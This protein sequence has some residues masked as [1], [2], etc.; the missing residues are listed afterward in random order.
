MIT[1]IDNSILHT[2]KEGT[3][4]KLT[5][6]M[7]D[8]YANM[9]KDAMRYQYELCKKRIELDKLKENNAYYNNKLVIRNRRNVATDVI[10]TINQMD[11]RINNMVR[12]LSI[13]LLISG[14]SIA[15]ICYTNTDKVN[16]S[17]GNFYDTIDRNILPD[18]KYIYDTWSLDDSGFISGYI[19]TIFNTIFRL[20]L[21]G[22]DGIKMIILSIVSIFIGLTEIG[23]V[24]ISG[25][26]FFIVVIITMLMI[27]LM[28]SSISIGL[29]GV[30]IK[31]NGN[32]GD[33]GKLKDTIVSY[34]GVSRT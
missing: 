19:F 29:M 34:F 22:I 1:E 33:I 30:D 18:S 23:A 6:K 31:E 9:R 27:K 13:L 7:V 28:T 10:Y 14:G 3:S 25:V 20:C 26:I 24:A 8:T 21:M 2:I 4:E 32:K 12:L 17:M 11:I 5:K 15:Y 16:K